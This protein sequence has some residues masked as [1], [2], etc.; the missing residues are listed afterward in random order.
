MKIRIQHIPEKFN[1]MRVLMYSTET[2]E[3]LTKNLFDCIISFKIINKFNG[4][5]SR[6]DSRKFNIHISKINK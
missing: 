4:K 6:R 3:K 1:L 2:I 5:T